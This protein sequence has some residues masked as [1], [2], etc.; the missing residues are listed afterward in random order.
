M[1]LCAVLPTG[2][3]FI[4]IQSLLDKSFT[5][6]MNFAGQPSC[7]QGNNC[8]VAFYQC[9]SQHAYQAIALAEN[10][11]ISR[12]VQ[13]FQKP[14]H[15]LLVTFPALAQFFLNLYLN[16]KARRARIIIK[17]NCAMRS[18]S[19]LAVISFIPHPPDQCTKLMNFC[20]LANLPIRAIF[21]AVALA[22]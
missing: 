1:V 12:I 21:C 14:H 19:N 15:S 22:R 7:P 3:T 16:P 11:L 5:K 8:A 2:C 13:I 6:L 17:K 10:S 20:G 4:I 9:V 18:V